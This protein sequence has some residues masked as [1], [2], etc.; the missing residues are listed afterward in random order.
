MARLVISVIEEYRKQGIHLLHA[1]TVMPDHFHVLITP[2]GSLSRAV[3]FIKG[4]S[5]HRIGKEMAPNLELWQRGFSHHQ[6]R[7]GADFR[8]HEEYIDFNAVKRG[9]AKIPSEYP[10]CSA[11]K[12]YEIDAP[13]TQFAG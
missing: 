2:E 7:N 10:Y 4:G 1:F 6:I 9:L 5:S 13:P 3:Q 12:L 11:T 8:G